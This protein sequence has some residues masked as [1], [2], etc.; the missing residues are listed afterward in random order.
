MPGALQRWMSRRLGHRPSRGERWAILG[1]IVAW[2]VVV[3]LAG[4]A[5]FILSGAS[6][7]TFLIFGGGIGSLFLLGAVTTVLA[8]RWEIPLFD[9]APVTDDEPSPAERSRKV[10]T[11]RRTLRW[12]IISGFLLL[13]VD[14]L[15]LLLSGDKSWLIRAL[16]LSVALA[17][18][19][20][21]YRYLSSSSTS[22]QS[23]HDPQA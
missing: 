15:I 2:S 23:S 1:P 8:I 17:S 14:L 9:P 20:L 21:L 16:V 7:W 13:V 3:G 19:L 5:S 11:R 12:L 10:S 6:L 18:C 22:S 4:A